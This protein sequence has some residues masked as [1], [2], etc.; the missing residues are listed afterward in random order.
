MKQEWILSA[1][2][3][4]KT[5]SPRA[6]NRRSQYRVV[7]E[8]LWSKNPRI[9][10]KDVASILHVDPRTASRIMI[11]AFDLGHVTKP[12]IRKRSY[13]NLKEYTY[14]VNCKRPLDSF[15]QYTE[16]MNI[17]FH[18]VMGGFSNL[19]VVS[20]EKINVEHDVIVVEGVRS[21][22]YAALAPQHSWAK[23]IKIMQEKV[24]TFSPNNY[25]PKGLIK[26]HWNETVEWDSEFEQL[27]RYFKY[28]LRRALTP[29]MKEHLITTGKIY[30]YLETLNECCTVYTRWFP[31]GASAYDPYLFMFKTDYEDFVIDLFSELPTSPIFFKVQDMLFMYT[32]VEKTSVRGVGIDM[33]DINQLHIPLLVRDLLRKGVIQSEAHALTEYYWRKKL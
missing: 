2:K 19:W 31:E 33:S 10:V 16:D 9:Y 24:D 22:Y 13:A 5:V 7:Y 21:D 29:V 8:L 15:V 28:D 18:A 17:A 3:G 30:K 4:V 12:Q 6:E 20:K 27:Y 11:E 25:E 26:T 32:Q 1:G 23:S 14:F